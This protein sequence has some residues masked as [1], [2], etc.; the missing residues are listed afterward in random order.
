MATKEND[1][2]KEFTYGNIT[3]TRNDYECMPCPMNTSSLSDYD[4]YRLA[5][6]I[7]TA[8]DKWSDWLKNGDIDQDQYDDQFWESMEYLGL[9]FGMTYY[10]D[11]D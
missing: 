2:N 3:I 4:M 8:M 11:E 6:A 10:E 5:K 7:Y 1:Y 9:M